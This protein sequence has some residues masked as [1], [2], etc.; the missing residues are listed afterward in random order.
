MLLTVKVSPNST[1]EKVLE[2]EN[3]YM[4]YTHSKAQAGEANVKVIELLAKHIDIA[5]S[6]ISIKS[7]HK[8]RYK[9]IEIPDNVL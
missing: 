4:I 5:K 6:L 2:S 1:A 3:G 8:S 7:G 9:I